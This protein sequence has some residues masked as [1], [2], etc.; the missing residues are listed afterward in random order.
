[1]TQPS[2]ESLRGASGRGELAA[3]FQPQVE[4]ATSRMVSCEAL[5]RWQHPE[6]G[7][8]PPATFIAVAESAGI[9]DEIGEFMFEA[10]LDFLQDSDA[11]GRPLDV[12]INVSPAQLTSQRFID[13]ILVMVA[14]RSVDPGR[15]TVEVT[16][17]VE[18]QDMSAVSG[19]L[20]LLRE[21]GMG[22]S[23]DDFGV[24]HSL[25]AQVLGLP[26]TEIKIDR[27]LVYRESEASD[28]SFHEA[29]KLASDLGLRTVA[30][31]VETAEHRDYAV[32]MGCNRAQGFLYG[33]PAREIDFSTLR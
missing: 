32:A 3:Y 8:I 30:E 20:G 26:A 31:G 18:I 13:K 10:G 16:E 14:A 5:C 17:S 25:A 15:I 33:R 27:T 6:M 9:I 22:I 11:A 21:L 28:I 23:I 7:E 4:L 19:R 29:M 12:A 24:G 2:G 1:M